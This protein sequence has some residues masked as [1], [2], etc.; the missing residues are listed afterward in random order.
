MTFQ[1]TLVD[2]NEVIME[3]AYEAIHSTTAGKYAIQMIFNGAAAYTI[4]NRELN[5]YAGNFIFL[6]Q[7]TSYSRKIDSERRVDSMSVRFDPDFVIDFEYARTAKTELLLDEPESHQRKAPV[8]V[9]AIY[10][11]QGDM[12]FNMLNLKKYLD[13]GSH[14]N[15]LLNTYLER[16]LVN[17]YAIYNEEVI[18]REASLNFLNHTTKS[19]ILRRLS[20]A[21]DYII[22]NYNKNICLEEIARIACLSVNHFLRTFKQA[23]HQS[24]HQFLTSIRLRQAKYFLRNTDY[25]VNEIVDIIGFECT[26]SF[27]RLFRNSFHV[28]P[29]QYR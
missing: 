20:I 12:K 10:P 25:P 22:S 7:D 8:F 16:C 4:A 24:P 19:E 21:R 18:S 9:E 23:Y 14:D 2:K 28:T 15:L 17:Y 5:L 6:N 29:G 27:I 1:S 11:L 3:S 13:Q 26:S